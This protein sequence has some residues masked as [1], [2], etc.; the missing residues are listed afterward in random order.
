M[1]SKC[2]WSLINE[3]APRYKHAPGVN[4][5]KSAVVRTQSA[6]RSGALLGD[7]W[8]TSSRCLLSQGMAVSTETGMS[9][10]GPFCHRSSLSP[11]PAGTAPSP[12]LLHPPPSALAHVS[13]STFPC[14]FC[15]PWVSERGVTLIQR[16]GDFGWNQC[17]LSWLINKKSC[18]WKQIWLLVGSYT[19]LAKP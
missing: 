12:P 11:H 10:N 1:W 6:T 7:N 15:C 3:K 5:N 19:F 2:C 13:A 17:L 14:S 8:F 18:N 16:L 4:F 9:P